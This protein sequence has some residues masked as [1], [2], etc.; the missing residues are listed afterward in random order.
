MRRNVAERQPKNKPYHL[1]RSLV[2]FLFLMLA[3]GSIAL[4]Q[5]GRNQSPAKSKPPSQP[6]YDSGNDKIS[7]PRAF[8]KIPP[9]SSEQEENRPTTADYNHLVRGAC[10]SELERVAGVKALE[11]E[12]LSNREARELAQFETDTYVIWME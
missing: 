12:N 8:M 6:V 2:V 1:C 7:G 11:D 3:L 4:A 9:A 10:M 5:S